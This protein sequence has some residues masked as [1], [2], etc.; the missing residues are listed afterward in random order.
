[1]RQSSSSRAAETTSSPERLRG[2]TVW[3]D[4]SGKCCFPRFMKAPTASGRAS[5][6][7]NWW[8][9][10]SK[11][12]CRCDWDYSCTRSCGIP[13]YAVYEGGSFAE[14][15]DLLPAVLIRANIGLPQ[16]VEPDS[17]NV[18]ILN[19]RGHQP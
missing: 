8:N 11:T 1:M 9:G 3:W 15:A 10:C 14:D 5:T 6:R 7:V 19:D 4:A 18:D 17:G 12:A 2:N 13:R 16:S